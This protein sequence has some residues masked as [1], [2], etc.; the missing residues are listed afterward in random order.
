MTLPASLEVDRNRYRADV[1]LLWPVPDLKE[2]LWGN[3]N[4]DRLVIDHARTTT[5]RLRGKATFRPSGLDLLYEERGT[6][7]FGEHCG[8]AEQTCRYDFPEGDGRALVRFREGRP[9]HE[10]DLSTGQDRARH[11]CPPDIYD[12]VFLALGPDAW[13]TEW[14]VTGPRKDYDL[15]TTYNR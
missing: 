1:P 9:F 6:L 7:V 8:Q 11:D 5:G 13:R 14:K 10:L 12:G 2:F 4:V 3:W 15:V